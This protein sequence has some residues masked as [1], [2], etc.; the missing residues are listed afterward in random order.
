MVWLFIIKFVLLEYVSFN[1]MI[2]IGRVEH[3][4][5]DNKDWAWLSG[6]LIA[7]IICILTFRLSDNQAVNDMF[8][9][10]ASAVSIALAFVAIGMAVK[11]DVENRRVQ[12]DVNGILTT[13]QFKMDSMNEEVKKITSDDVLSMAIQKT[14]DLMKE[15][16]KDS[17]TKQEVNKLIN[18]ALVDYGKNFIDSINSQRSIFDE[19]DKSRERRNAEM[20]DYMLNNPNV[21]LSEVAKKFK[22]SN[23]IAAKVIKNYHE[24]KS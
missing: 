5:W 23:A 22:V 3:M 18:D 7:I 8:S 12:D 11:Q 13:I 9:F 1:T 20:L 24:N 10:V 16:D 19:F 17:Y 4:K 14:D 6:I 2:S 21:K 15:E